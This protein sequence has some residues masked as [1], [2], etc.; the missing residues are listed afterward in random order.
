MRAL[1]RTVP[2]D[3]PGAVVFILLGPFPPRS[4]LPCH[5]EVLIVHSTC[6]RKGVPRPPCA[7]PSGPSSHSAV[8]CPRVFCSV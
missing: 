8:C 5:W 2:G 3:L 4:L 7:L 6:R 1:G